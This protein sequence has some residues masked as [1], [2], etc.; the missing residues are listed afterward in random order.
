M[1]RL[2]PLA[3]CAWILIGP[4][5][6]TA[7]LPSSDSLP[8]TRIVIDQRVAPWGKNL[9]DL[10][11]DGFLD[12]V[13]GGGALGRNVYW[14]HYPSWTRYLIG[15]RGGG[16]DVQV[17][18]INGDGALDVVVNGREI[19]W[20]ENPR[21]S[22]G[23]PRGQWTP[24]TIDVTTGA[25][26]LIVGDVNRDGKPDVIIRQPLGKTILY[27]QVSP[28]SWTTVALPTAPPGQGLALADIDRDGRPDI[29]ANGFWLAQPPDPVRGVWALH[30]F[31]DWNNSAS[32]A[33]AD[34]NGDGRAD[35]LLAAS[36]TGVGKIAWFEA[37]ADPIRGRWVRHD[38]DTVEDVHR[39]HVVDVNRDGRPD[40]VFAEMHQSRTRRV[41]IYYNQG[42]GLSWKAQILATTGSHNVAI[43]D[44]GKE[45][46]LDIL[47]A[48][49]DLSSPDG[50]ALVLWH[51][52]PAR[53][54]LLSL[55]RWEYIEVD[56][57]RAD[58]AFGLTFGDLDGDGRPDIVSGPYWYRNPGGDLKGRWVRTEIDRETD[59]ML[60]LDVDGDGRL[61]VIGQKAAGSG[62]GVF[63][64]KPLDAPAI[65]WRRTLI[66]TLPGG[67]RD[68]TSQGSAIA[69]L[70]PGPRPQMLFSSDRGIFYFTI[71]SDPAAGNWPMVQVATDAT[72]EGIATG[73]LDGDGR[74]DI[75]GSTHAR[76]DL[77]G[78]EVA[79]W[80]NPGEGRAGWVKRVIGSTPLEIDRVRV[81]DL[82]QDGRLDVIV[83]DTDYQTGTGHL[84]WFEQQPGG[85]W[86]RHTIA[87]GMGALHSLDVADFNGDGR[88]D[89]V[90][91]E[92]RGRG[93]R[94][95]IWENVDGG[96]R[97]R[98]HVVDSGKESHLGTQVHDL[99]G[100][101]ALDIVSIAWDKYQYLHL[102]RND[103]V[104]RGAR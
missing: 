91:G 61:D 35:I 54:G 37:P 44:V 43:G 99:D 2:R 28:D 65:W 5:C 72:Q 90:V 29:V 22:G 46:G 26:D 4:G 13:V 85:A 75:V 57:S 95:I 17:A 20:Y 39:L 25:H 18:D 68:V 81:A 83:T 31:G 51:L 74:I 92:H 94:T 73:D 66:G 15:V 96:R 11:G 27:L 41:G 102:W 45:G 47:G 80:R 55:D 88:V 53:P 69:Q 67:S 48:N 36:E 78:R 40:I 86:V 79:W 97:W 50:G 82:N 98:S 42:G 7:T 52:A 60:A 32:V 87:D 10:D 62:V 21:G 104:R 3:L 76:P 1:S 59:A 77:P 70:N 56:R 8:F 6:G 14:Y 101:G 93:L 9:A 63:W 30:T 33:V 38:I 16:D 103:A 24:H 71:P 84:Y 49:W 12:V 100:D 23:D 64:Y 58:T 89:I 19:V 34:I